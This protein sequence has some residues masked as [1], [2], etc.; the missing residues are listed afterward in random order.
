MNPVVQ[1]THLSEYGT[2]KCL[3]VGLFVWCPGCDKPHRFSIRCE[4]HGGP[5][6]NVVWTFD[7]NL[8]APT[9]SPSYIT[10]WV[11]V[12]NDKKVE[13]VC[14]SFLRVGV[15]DFLADST[16]SLASQKVP[17]VPLPDWLVKKP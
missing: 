9:F 2:E 7:G 5:P 4:E 1:K 11:G 6:G 3:G 15:W 12:E 13:K 16:H 14:H 10:R 17:M 8:E